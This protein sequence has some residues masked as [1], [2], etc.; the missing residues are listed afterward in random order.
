MLVL[1]DVHTYYGDSYVL[2]GVSLE[3]PVGRTTVLM[4]RNGAGKTTTMRTIFA[5]TPARRGAVFVDGTDVTAGPTHRIARLGVALVPQGRHIFP[6]LSVREH[7]Q[8][9]FRSTS[10]KGAWDIDR[11]LRLFPPL[12]QRFHVRAAH[13]SGGEQSMLAIARAL[14][15]QPAC[16]LLDEPTEGLAPLYVEAVLAAIQA[17]K[18]ENLALLAVLPE[19]PLA[20]AVA[21]YIYVMEKGRIVFEGAPTEL[22]INEEVQLRHIGLGAGGAR[23]NL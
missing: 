20:L 23:D 3:A 13:L 22:Q 6:S 9:G 19:L 8:V 10:R 14:L 12:S 4:G 7:L 16:L 2:Q 15:T 21:D 1:Q 11:V 18:A 17:L 5:L